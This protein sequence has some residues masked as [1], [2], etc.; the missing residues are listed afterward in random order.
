M[1]YK[2]ILQAAQIV[3]LV[4]IP[5]KLVYAASNEDYIYDGKHFTTTSRCEAVTK[6]TYPFYILDQDLFNNQTQIQQGTLIEMVGA[7]N[8]YDSDRSFRI[9]KT[10]TAN[11]AGGVHTLP[12]PY[13]DSP[14]NYYLQVVQSKDTPFGS[15]KN[16]TMRVYHRDNKSYFQ[17]CCTSS[18]CV[19]LPIFAVFDKTNLIGTIA[20]QPGKNDFIT[21]YKALRN[22]GKTTLPVKAT[23]PLKTTAAPVGDADGTATTVASTTVPTPTPSPL[24]AETPVVAAEQKVICTQSAPLRIYDESLKKV[25]YS[26]PKYLPVKVYQSWSGGPEQKTVKGH[27]VVKVQLTTGAG[28][29]ITGWA[30]GSYIKPAQ[31]CKG[32]PLIFSPD[33][34]EEPIPGATVVTE[35]PGDCC[36]FPTLKAPSADYDHGDGGRWFGARRR[37]GKRL[38]AAAD[39]LRPEGEKVFSIDGGQVLRK[40]H[41]YAGT[42]ALEVKHD[43]GL[44]ARYGEVAKKNVAQSEPGERV[45]KGQH[46]GFIGSLDMLHFELYSNKS[47]GPL[48]QVNAG[49][50]WRRSDLIDPTPLLKKWQDMTF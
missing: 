15:L 38:H 42:Y 29:D 7:M 48:T 33:G 14:T 37:D 34:E 31:E 40:Y 12:L 16:K 4:I 6:S 11:A 5:K 46:I 25:I 13:A 28:K 22:D 2:L 24:P 26:A 44:V 30:A 35:A 21:S 17:R 27:Q 8:I 23:P 47:Q 50:Y 41:F 32:M 36:R 45:L 9:L 3:F 43:N 20:F 19:D 49:K 10:P 39:L 18:K 1:S